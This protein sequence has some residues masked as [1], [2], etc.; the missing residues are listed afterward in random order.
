MK[1]YIVPVYWTISARAIVEA[2]SMEDAADFAAGMDIDSF[3]NP[4]ISSRPEIGWDLI[5]S[6]N[7]DPATDR[8]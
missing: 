8:D 3:D 7:H 5:E 2:E 6:V 1:K 4:A